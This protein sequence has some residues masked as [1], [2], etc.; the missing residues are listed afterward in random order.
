MYRIL[1]NKNNS[2]CRLCK[3]K[4]GGWVT[5]NVYPDILKL[6]KGLEKLNINIDEVTQEYD[7]EID[8]LDKIDNIVTIVDVVRENIKECEKLTSVD[9]LKSFMVEELQSI[10]NKKKLTSFLYHMNKKPTLESTLKYLYDCI[11]SSEGLGAY[12][13][14][15]S[16]KG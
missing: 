10:T 12:P 3:S 8:D 1:Y 16:T 13:T 6:L 2:T 14:R 7:D 4:D 11:L 15:Y 9:D 5:Q